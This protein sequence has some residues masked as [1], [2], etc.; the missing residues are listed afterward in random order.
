M[1]GPASPGAPAPPGQH[2]CLLGRHPVRD[3]EVG[4]VGPEPELIRHKLHLEE[5]GMRQLRQ[6]GQLGQLGS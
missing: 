4:G 5:R 3:V 2:L 1:S 6:L